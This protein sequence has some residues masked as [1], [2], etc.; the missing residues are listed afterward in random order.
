MIS[1]RNLTFAYAPVH[2]DGAPVEV[3]RDLDLHLEPGAFQA[4][5][6]ASGSG[7][8]TLC[9]IL[10]GLAPRYTGGTISGHISV[11]NQ[12]VIAQMPPTGQVGLLFQDA[13][14]QLFTTS[15]EEE[16]AW[17]LEAIGVP[18]SEI[19]ARITQ[20]LARFGL[21]R[22][23]HRPP[24]ALSGGQQKRLALAALWAL[25]PKVLILDE[26]LGGLDPEG[27]SEVLATI[28]DLHQTGTT[29]LVMTLRPQTALRAMNL[30]LLLEGQLTRPDVPTTVLSQQ[31]SLVMNGI[32][33]P[34]ELWP[35]LH[36][37]DPIRDSDP[38]IEI[39]DLHYSYTEEEEVLH[40]IDLTIPQGQF[41]ALIGAN[42]AGKST[43][44]R[45]LNGLLRTKHGHVVIMGSPVA[46]RPIGEIAHDVGFLFQRPEQQFFAATVRAEIAYGPQQLKLSDIEARTVAALTRFDLE[47]V[48]EVPPALLGYGAQRTVTLAS[49]SALDNPIV[50]LDEPTVGL[51]GHGMAQLLTW[52]AELRTQG[53]TLVLVTHEMPLA[54]RADRVVALADGNIVADGPPDTV[55]ST[56][57]W[58]EDAP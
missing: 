51:D 40:G 52:I 9:H 57:Q 24:W 34:P 49:L 50:V 42:G 32:L 13:A 26:P 46:K 21:A 36:S 45:H 25:Q 8:S 44:I 20:A 58:S 5:M 3:L 38:A 27:R 12:D 2:P 35:D 48:A 16:I 53:V 19:E 4:V 41:V 47:D 54:A 55:L 6:G 18:A 31:A 28:A 43:L 29:L 1:A 11:A 17:G 33:Y 56:L 30:S 37:R 10:A 7:K 22:L 14:T 15:A 39:R 23:R